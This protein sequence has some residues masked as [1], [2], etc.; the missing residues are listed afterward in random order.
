[1]VESVLW[2]DLQKTGIILYA[3]LLKA[4]LFEN[5]KETISD[6]CIICAN[7]KHILVETK[8]GKSIYYILLLKGGTK[9]IINQKINDY[10]YTKIQ[11][12]IIIVIMVIRIEHQ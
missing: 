4:N 10:N 9:S 11:T 6:L 5:S 2:H 8:K 12:S 1:M 3:I 7:S